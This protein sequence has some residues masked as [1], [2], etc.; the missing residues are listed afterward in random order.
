MPDV[1]ARP[2]EKAMTSVKD[3]KDPSERQRCH[4]CKKWFH[5]ADGGFLEERGSGRSWDRARL[6]DEG[7]LVF[8]CE[9]CEPN[10]APRD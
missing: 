10:M 3:V 6:D 4:K 1:R 8:I 9:N 7:R 2:R 5:L